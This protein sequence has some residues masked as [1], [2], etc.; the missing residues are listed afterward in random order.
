MQRA[1]EYRLFLRP[2]YAEL[3]KRMKASQTRAMGNLII[4]LASLILQTLQ[5]STRIYRLFGLKCILFRHSDN[6]YLLILLA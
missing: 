2:Y 4:L 6:F 1:F 5:G 3:C